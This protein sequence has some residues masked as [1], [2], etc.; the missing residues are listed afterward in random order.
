MSGCVP[1]L[2]FKIYPLGKDGEKKGHALFKAREESGCCT[3]QCMG[4]DCRPFVMK[5]KL[6]DE[7]EELDNEPFLLIDREC[8]CTFLCF[9]RPEITVTYNEDGK[10]IYLGK[11]VNPW[12]CCNVTLDIF[13]A[14]GAKKYVVEASCCQLGFHIKAPCESCQTIDFDIKSPS[15]EVVATLQKRSP[16]CAGALAN[17]ENFLIHF[18]KNATKEDK[19]L[20]MAA[21]LFADYRFFEKKHGGPAGLSD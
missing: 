7:S 20:L 15:G 5:V 17:L 1:P 21:V 11:V 18:P 8:K 4:G 14:A 2:Q 16:G 13:D 9:N 6:D 10:D 12:T 3:R 19:A